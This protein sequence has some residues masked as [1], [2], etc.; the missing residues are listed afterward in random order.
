LYSLYQ[1]LTPTGTVISYLLDEPKILGLIILVVL[2]LSIIATLPLWEFVFYI[3]LTNSRTW[4]Y[5][6]NWSRFVHAALPLQLALVQMLLKFIQSGFLY[7]YNL[8]RNYLVEY[9]CLLYEQCIPITYM[10][11]VDTNK[12]KASTTKSNTVSTIEDDED[13]TDDNDDE[14]DE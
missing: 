10:E 3:I 7:I 6:P 14:E 13:D 1:H 9:E 4:M 12:N 5:W 11:G 2:I 8:V